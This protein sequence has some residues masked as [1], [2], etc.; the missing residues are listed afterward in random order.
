MEIA[1]TLFFWWKIIQDLLIFVYLICP[2]RAELNAEKLIVGR[3]EMPSPSLNIIC[4]IYW[5]KYKTPSHFNGLVLGCTA[6][7]KVLNIVS[8]SCITELR[9]IKAHFYWLAIA[10]FFLKIYLWICSF[11]KCFVEVVKF[12]KT[13]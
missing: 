5:F 13:H 7:L 4:T 2:K 12:C 8:R 1:E 6:Y 11:K 10:G 9:S 3:R